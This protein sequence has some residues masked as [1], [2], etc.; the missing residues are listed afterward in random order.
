M[1]VFVEEHRTEDTCTDAE[2]FITAHLQ[3]HYHTIS[4]DR[5]FQQTANETA[6]MAA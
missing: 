6:A 1:P 4:S 5:I 2:L 3:S